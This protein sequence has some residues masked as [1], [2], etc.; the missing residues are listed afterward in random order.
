MKLPHG[1]PGS[2][3]SEHIFEALCLGMDN[4]DV[5][6][7]LTLREYAGVTQI[8][9]YDPEN[10]LDSVGMR[11]EMRLELHRLGG[12]LIGQLAWRS[13]YGGYD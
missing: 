7:Q 9:V 6:A 13:L 1:L 11:V 10:N 2:Q 3:V 8:I 5:P 4:L 12:Y